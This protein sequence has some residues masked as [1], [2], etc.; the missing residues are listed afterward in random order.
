MSHIVINTTSVRDC[1]IGILSVLDTGFRCFT[2]ELPWLNNIPYESCIP[3]G[4]YKWHKHMS[5]S[6]GMVLHILDVDDRTWIYIHQGNFTHQIKGCV[7]VGTMLK[8]LDGDGIP[9]VG[10][11]EKAFT[12]LMEMLPDEGKVTIQR[13]TM[14]G[15]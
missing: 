14:R 5:P 10:N 7:L 15:I 13:N 3:S 6:L 8:D 11:S 9:D 12:E 2:L 1:T 4:V